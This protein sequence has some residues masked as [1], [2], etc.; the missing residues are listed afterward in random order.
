M[1]RSPKAP[2]PWRQRVRLR[3][4][5]KANARADWSAEQWQRFDAARAAKRTRRRLIRVLKTQRLRELARREDSARRS[6]RM[7]AYH[8]RRRAAAHD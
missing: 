2:K 5:R 3:Q 6:A 8:A 4:N 7:I 1:K